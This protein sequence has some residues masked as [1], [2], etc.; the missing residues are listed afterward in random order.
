MKVV[1]LMQ[2]HFMKCVRDIYMRT[3]NFTSLNFV[4]ALRTM[5]T[6]GGISPPRRSSKID[7]FLETFSR[8]YY[9]ANKSDF[10]G[11]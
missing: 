5:L 9:E 7:R 1:Q 2:I 6:K 11:C 3:M 8:I 10:K 4:E